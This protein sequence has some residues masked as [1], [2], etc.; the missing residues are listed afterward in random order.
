MKL[1]FVWAAILCASFA[2]DSAAQSVKMPSAVPYAEDNDISDAIKAECDLPGRFAEYIRK[3]SP[4]PVELTADPVDTASGRV[5]KVE[6]VDAVSMGNAWLGH[7]KYTKVRGSL[8]QDGNKL[9]SFKGRR[10]SMGGAF[11][12]YK[13][14][15]SVL[16]RTIEALGEDIGGWL[17]N[18]V[19]GANIGD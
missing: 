4:V 10:N 5:L 9:A 16:D 8:W 18:P 6:I 2:A 11:A 3:S 17:S 19:D 1:R 7:Q 14:S 15:C 13:G 12:G